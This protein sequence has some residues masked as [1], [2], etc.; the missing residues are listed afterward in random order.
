LRQLCQF[1]SSL[2]LLAQVHRPES[3]SSHPLGDREN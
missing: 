2:S 1:F 3:D